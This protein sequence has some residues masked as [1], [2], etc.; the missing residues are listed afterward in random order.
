LIGVAG[1][2]VA[3]EP[4][5]SSTV[6]DAPP[7]APQQA[8]L[9]PAAAPKL[10]VEPPYWD[11]GDVWQG[12][13]LS[14][15]VVL[16]NTGEGEL[17]I[18]H[19]RCNCGCTA[20]K[21]DRDVLKP[22]ETARMTVTF[23]SLKKRG[24]VNQACTITSNDPSKPN[25]SFR[26]TGVVDKVYDLEPQE[27]LVFGTLT[28]DSAEERKAEL[29]IKYTEPVKLEL[30]S[31]S[32]G[33]FDV[34][35]KTIEE[36]KRYEITAKTRPPLPNGAVRKDI[37]LETGLDL[38]P[39]I[40]LQTYAYVQ[41]KVAVTPDFLLVPIRL[42]RETERTIKVSYLAGEPI[43]ITGFKSEPE[44]MITA[45]LMDQPESTADTLFARKL[46]RVS[47]PAGDKIP[48]D[49]AKLIIET[50]AK[51]PEFARLEV[52]V[53]NHSRTPRVGQAGSIRPAPRRPGAAAGDAS[54]LTPS[55]PVKEADEP[56]PKPEPDEG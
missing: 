39:T 49:G 56:A 11:F 3:Q 29:V 36:G 54:G 38:V 7:A 32:D 5:P 44:G 22:G 31:E 6:T 53:S 23:N 52:A 24:R 12:T 42:Q 47:L 35:I 15:E 14:K 1:L 21:P 9:N 20:A 34:S 17:K 19:V 43:E 26:V 37:V 10:E 33:P 41:P 40:R 4:P 46:I 30:K 45:T 25:Y 2:V 51:D 55:P 16:K 50:S 28:R 18:E 48:A 27:G 8:A 13:P